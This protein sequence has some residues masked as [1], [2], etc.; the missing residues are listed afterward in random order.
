MNVDIDLKNGV[1]VREILHDVNSS[2][3]KGPRLF[4]SSLVAHALSPLRQGVQITT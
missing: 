2:V 3:Y 1:R 4:T